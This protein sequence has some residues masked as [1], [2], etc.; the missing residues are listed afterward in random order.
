MHPAISIIV[1]STFSGVGFGIGFWLGILGNGNQSPAVV[2][3]GLL[4]LVWASVGLISSVFHLRRPARAI[5]AFSQWRSSWLSREGILAILTL[6]CIFLYIVLRLL[7][8]HGPGVLVLA[9]II[10]L[11][12][13]ATVYSTAMIYAQLR[14]VPAWNT[15]LTPLVFIGFSLLG[16]GTFCFSFLPDFLSRDFEFIILILLVGGWVIW[17]LW[18]L[19]RDRIGMGASSVETATQ[20]G[21]LG[22]VRPFEPPHMGPNY[23][24][25]EMGYRLSKSKSTQLRGLAV[26]L[27]L[28][29]PILLYC[30]VFIYQD[31]GFANV[32]RIL[33]FCFVLSGIFISRWLFFAESRH[34]TMLYY[35]NEN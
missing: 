14:A 16:G 10:S 1:F 4:A 3:T 27:G 19:R 18:S 24:T 21:K 30:I 5:R 25:R 8:I 20:L 23:L 13:L 33:L 7:N 22:T 11:L 35:R 26:A 28:I 31:S 29:I 15:V 12:S 2:I 17:I 34:T 32:S 6:G 9:W